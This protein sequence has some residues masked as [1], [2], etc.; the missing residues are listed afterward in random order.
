MTKILTYL[1][2]NFS[3]DD[4]QPDVRVRRDS[5]RRASHRDW[6]STVQDHERRRTPHNGLRAVPR[7]IC[8]GNQNDHIADTGGPFASYSW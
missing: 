6:S 1:Y 5:P 3:G 4:P 7:Q 2:I 8:Q